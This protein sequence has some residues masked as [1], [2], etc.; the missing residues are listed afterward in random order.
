L[1]GARS[2]SRTDCTA[3]SDSGKPSPLLGLGGVVLLYSLPHLLLE[4]QSRYHMLM[5]PYFVVG[6]VFLVHKLAATPPFLP[7]RDGGRQQN[8]L[9]HPAP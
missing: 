6:A 2:A 1:R 4:V 9:R 3:T 7:P 8:L 5:L